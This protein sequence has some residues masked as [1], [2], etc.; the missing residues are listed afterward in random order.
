VTQSRQPGSSAHQELLS[1]ASMQDKA[2]GNT[3]KLAAHSSQ[4]AWQ[5]SGTP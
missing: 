1:T 4:V 2:R 3:N 5:P